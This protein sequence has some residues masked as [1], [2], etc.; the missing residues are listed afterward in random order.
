M[1][2][3]AWTILRTAALMAGVAV[4]SAGCGSF[5][6]APSNA[7]VNGV[8]GIDRDA[9]TAQLSVSGLDRHGE[10]VRQGRVGSIKATVDQPGFAVDGGVCGHIAWKGPITGA[11]TLDGS[12]SMATNDPLKKRGTGARE[13]VSRMGEGDRI[14]VTSFAGTKHV[15]H[16]DFTSDK[17]TLNAAI[18]NA[19]FANGATPLWDASYG[20]TGHL[21]EEGGNNLM[22]LIFTDGEDTGGRENPRSVIDYAQRENVRLY[23]VGL[24]GPG[25]LETENMTNIA[26]ET[27]GS[28]IDIEVEDVDGLPILFNN[29]FSASKA[30]GCISLDFDP[31]PARGQRM[32]G[33]LNFSINRQ[34]FTGTYGVTF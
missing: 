8:T 11:L 21:A 22:A 25:T 29:I 4:L 5:G 9:G 17:D 23:M 10:V 6:P 27:G 24:G 16:A 20:I 31:V 30:A 12:G 13:F 14:A 15:L 1:K 18:D 34:Q 33:E 28:Y 32:T 3:K 19:V 2:T 7:T 26:V